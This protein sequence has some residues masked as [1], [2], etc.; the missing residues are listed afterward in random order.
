M[1]VT[2][3]LTRLREVTNPKFYPLYNNRSRFLILYGG[4]GSGKSTFTAQKFTY[5]TLAE[6]GHKFL[7]VR[8]VARTL[9]ESA[10]AELRGVIADWGLGQ[11]FTINRGDMHIRCANGNEFVFAGLDD[12]EK[13]KSIHGITSVWVEEATEI[14][15]EDLQQL[16]LR[17]RGET[18]HYKQIVLSL[19]P[20]NILH[21]IKGVVDE[22]GPDVTAVKSTYLDN[23]FIDDEYKRVIEALRETDPYL[24]QVYG[25]G[26]W[27]VMGATVYPAQIVTERLL[28]IRD[29]KPLRTGR[30][31]YAE[32]EGRIHDTSIE[33][34]EDENG[35][36]RIF[37][38]PGKGMPYV[39]GGDTAEGGEDYCTGSVRDNVTWQQVASYRERTD[40]DLFAKQMYCLGRYYHDALIGIETNFDLHP[41]KELERLGYPKQ[42]MRETIDEISRVRQHKHGFRTTKLTRATIISKHV[43][44]AREHIDTFMEPRLLEEMLTF[45]RN[46]QGR[47]EAQE[48]QHDDLILADAIALEIRTQ[49]RMSRNEEKKPLTGTYHVGELKLMGYTEA[50]I[51][52]MKRNGGVRI[53]G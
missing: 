9:R 15:K 24:Y 35:P 47:P 4:A 52:Q 29:K 3:D 48:G 1:A 8:K 40:T 33:F 30:F 20:I 42:Y 28:A 32:Q 26:E 45:V 25:L 43:A 10:F 51:R 12:V 21:W 14:T 36:V 34:V 7:V 39:I 6:R 19:N 44:L 17:L 37:A 38:E 41:V 2:I 53:L 16:N 50:Q 27:G 46:E 49:Q 18:Q 22:G 5:R 31:I 13:L 23:L 11:L